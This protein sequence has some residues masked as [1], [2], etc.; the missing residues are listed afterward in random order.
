MSKQSKREKLEEI[1]IVQPKFFDFDNYPTEG[2]G[3]NSRNHYI[4]LDNGE[5][6]DYGDVLTNGIKIEVLWPNGKTSTHIVKCETKSDSFYCSDAC[7]TF[8]TIK[9]FPFISIE[10]NDVWLGKVKLTSIESIKIRILKE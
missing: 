4:H 5:A 3:R 1:E 2:Y 7:E 9:Y 10:H 8:H 6:D